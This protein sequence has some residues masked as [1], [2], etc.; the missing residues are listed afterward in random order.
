M[1]VV[2]L[3]LINGLEGHDLNIEIRP[4][5]FVLFGEVRKDQPE[6]LWSLIFCKIFVKS[7]LTLVL[8]GE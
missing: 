7:K 3:L 6:E 5:L 4:D 2:V 8:Q 1:N